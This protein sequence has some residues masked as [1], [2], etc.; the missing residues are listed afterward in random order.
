M[1]SIQKLTLSEKYHKH[2]TTHTHKHGE[3][4]REKLLFLFVN[5]L[6]Y[7]QGTSLWCLLCCHGNRRLARTH[8]IRYSVIDAWLLCLTHTLHATHTWHHKNGLILHLVA[9]S[10]FAWLFFT[11]VFYRKLQ[12][13]IIDTLISTS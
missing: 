2:T 3:K 11:V 6:C 1:Q 10:F 8:H 7:V 4:H 13:C 9:S 5:I 12:W